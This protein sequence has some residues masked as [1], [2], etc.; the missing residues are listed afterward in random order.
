MDQFINVLRQNGYKIT[1]QRL[2]VLHILKKY[3]DAHLSSEEVF[4]KLI[5]EG[6]D[7]G[8]ATVYR[9]LQLMEECGL[10]YKLD[11]NGKLSL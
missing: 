10:V 1:D 4:E 11:L 8:I 7:I 3:R 2:D 6:K 5:E 9:T